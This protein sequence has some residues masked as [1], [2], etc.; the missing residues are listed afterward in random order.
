M[1]AAAL[2]ALSQAKGYNIICFAHLTNSMAQKEGD[3]EKGR[4]F[5]SIDMS[6]LSSS[7]LNTIQPKKLI[8]KWKLNW[9]E[10]W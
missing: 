4:E 7:V 2:Y 9:R 1:E 3:F 6:N 5:G 10:N 8:G